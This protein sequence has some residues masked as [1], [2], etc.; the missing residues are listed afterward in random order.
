M[1]KQIMILRSLIL[2]ATLA[3]CSGFVVAVSAQTPANTP[4]KEQPPAPAPAR[5][6]QLAPR[7]HYVL[8]NGMQV[9]LLQYGT[10]P[11]VSIEIDEAAGKVN[12]D[13]QHIDL[14]AI[15]AELMAEGT[16]KHTGEEL[17]RQA[18]DM[19]SSLSIQGGV[20][21]STFSIDVLSAS[22]AEAISLLAEVIEQPAFPDKDLE[23]LRA[24]HLRSRATSLANPGF[25][26]R[27]AFAQVMYGDQAY[28]RLLP[29][30]TM[31]KSYTLDDIRSF[32][33]ANY[34][35][36]RT[37]IYV[38]GRFDEKAV[39][40][41]IDK[42][43]RGWTRGP[44]PQMPVQT[45]AS[46]VH[47]AFVDQ[48]GAAQSNVIYG[49]A[50]PDVTSPDATQLAVMNSLLGGSF[51]SRITSN[52]REQKGYTYS[53]RSSLSQ[54][55]GT[56]VWAENA[57]ITTV[58]TGPAIQEIVKEIKRLQDAPPTAA[59]LGGI[60]RYE[61]GVF[62]LRNSS[63]GGILANLSFVDFHRLSDDY[64]TGYVQRVDAIT[65]E[66]VQDMAKK[67]LNTDAMALVVVGDPA[68]VKPQLSGFA[69][70]AK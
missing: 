53:P 19:G 12:E 30:E 17:A 3:H 46:G 2:V 67:Y 51:G 21:Q 11:K 45:A 4:A 37:A 1:G 15:M 36:Q 40:V 69:A 5:P 48:P 57:A 26:S 7:T 58:S 49:I 32:Y 34:G 35:S 13:P 60:Q 8:P 18:G 38:V 39:R 56:N 54:G 31:L 20:Y 25:L 70:G 9:N 41:A 28:G 42:S 43:F 64:L 16:T 66:Q 52:I 14:S 6:F 22:A 29:T 59:E 68:I 44:A 24:D 55:Y 65:P 50:V 47:F 33:A 23:R 62:V 10:V 27:Q 61:D 63:R